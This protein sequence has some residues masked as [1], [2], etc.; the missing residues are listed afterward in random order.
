MKE[1]LI[2]QQFPILK[3]IVY[4][5]SAALVLK[6]LRA[7]EAS[8]NFYLH[9]SISSRTADTPKGII[10]NQKINQ[11]RQKV[12]DLID[13]KSDNVI[14]TSGTTDSLNIFASMAKQILKEGDEFLISAYNH[15][16]NIL[17]WIEICNETKAKVIISEN[18]LQD[19]NPQTKFIALSQ[20]TNN[21]NLALDYVNIYK[22]AKENNAFVINDAAQAIVHQK[23]SMN[24]CDVV[25]FSSNKM[26]GPTGMGVLAV[27][28]QILKQIKPTRFGGGSVHEIKKDNTWIAKETIQ[29]FEP[30]TPN[31]AGIFMFDEA[32]NFLNELTYAKTEQ[33]LRELSFYLHEK[34]ASLE[35]VTLYTQKGDYIALINVKG[36]NSQDVC[37]YLGERNIYTISGIFC[38]PYLRNIKDS[39]S[40]LR[41]SLGVYNTKEDIDKLIFELKNGGDFYAF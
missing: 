1:N 34:L 28:D 20:E 14:F 24:Y 18:I 9:N 23:V 5:D 21:F 25:V 17:P 13:T 31:L 7:I 10:V 6:P 36:V 22:K 3:E 8:N 2:R 16:S 30:G 37:T 32:I 11:L 41:I 33:I 27:K 38:A 4:F 35:N 26:Y 40:Y 19:I 15:S 12:A 29:V 39:F